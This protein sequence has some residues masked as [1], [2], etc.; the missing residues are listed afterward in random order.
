MAQ[1]LGHGFLSGQTGFESHDG[2]DFFSCASFLCYDFHVVRWRLVRD[3]TI[4]RRKWL[5]IIINDFLEKGECYDLALL[6]L[7]ISLGRLCIACRYTISDNCV[8][9]ST[10]RFSG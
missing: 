2:R 6:P 9:K 8:R 5:H 1:W 4:L 7:I 10:V 3:W